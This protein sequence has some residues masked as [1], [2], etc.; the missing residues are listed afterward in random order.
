MATQGIAP[1]VEYFKDIQ[2]PRV[3]RNKR[4]S[5]LDIIVVTFLAV[6][7][8]AMGWEDIEEYAQCKEAWLKKFGLLEHGLPHHDTYRRV[9]ARLVPQQMEECFMAWVRSIKREI[10]H[11]VI[12]VDGKTIRGSFDAHRGLKAAHMVSAWATENRMVFAQVKV[13]EKH[14]EITAIPELLSMIALS[15]CIVTIDAMGCQ[16]E[17]ANQIKEADADY[18][19]SL[20]GNQGNLHADVKEYFRDC[21]YDEPEGEVRFHT[22]VDV[23]H[24]RIETRHHTCTDDVQWLH[25]RHPKWHSIRSIGLITSQRD[26]NGTVSSE[27]RYYVSSLPA[28]PELFATTARAHWSI[29]NSL[30]YVLDVAFQEDACR[31]KS[32][33]APENMAF[34]RKVALTA[35]R[36]DT[37]SKRSLKGRIKNLSWSDQYVEKILFHTTFPDKPLKTTSNSA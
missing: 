17:I 22:T 9:F 33:H 5:L 30:H 24:G 28:T 6:L 23:D 31:I 25:E 35:V 16:Y 37:G 34:I 20:K 15:G 11:E 1:L 32:G 4:H 29:E 36:A 19:F 27:T 21:D 2:D 13:D 3:E 10:P 14:N 18:L 12:A 26:V 8:G 7:C